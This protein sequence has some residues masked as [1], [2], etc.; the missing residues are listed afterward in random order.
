VDRLLENGDIER[1]LGS[2]RLQAVAQRVLASDGAKQ[3]VDT[4]FESGLFDHFMERL[5]ESDALWRLVDVIA[6]SP[7]V[8][9]AVSQQGL[10]FADQVGGEVRRRS[11]R[12]DERLEQIAHRLAHRR[13]NA[14]REGTAE[15][16]AEPPEPGS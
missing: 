9:A 6:Q 3:L 7:A 11:R 14:E 4:F 5:G 10:G 13:Q 1:L 2:P 15:S 8:S 16:A 12:V